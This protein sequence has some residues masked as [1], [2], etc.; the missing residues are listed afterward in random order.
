LQRI[1]T[2]PENAVRNFLANAEADVSEELSKITAPTLVMH[3]RDEV[4]VPLARGRSPAAGIPGARFISP[5]SRNHLI[6]ESEP[7]FARFANEI[8]SFLRD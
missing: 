4:A 8:V 1:S 3:A 7:A 6:L 5:P 2:S